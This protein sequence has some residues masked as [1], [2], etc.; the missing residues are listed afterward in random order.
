M[1]KI[2]AGPSG[3]REG[4]SNIVVDLKYGKPAGVDLNC[5][6]SVLFNNIAA[7]EAIELLGGQLGTCR[8][9]DRK[10]GHPFSALFASSSI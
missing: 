6:C 1:V 7:I 2:V 4:S 5:M 8:P 3:S 9:C 10:E